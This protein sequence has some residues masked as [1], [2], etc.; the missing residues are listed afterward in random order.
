MNVARAVELAISKVI[1]DHAQ[2]GE[3][4][5]VRPWQ[6]LRYDGSWVEDQDRTF[7]VVSVA[8]QPPQQDGNESTAHI[9][10]A[11]VMATKTDDDRDHAAISALYDAVQGVMDEAYGQFMRQ[12][13]GVELNAITDVLAQE[14]G[15]GFH[16]GGLSWGNA[17]SPNEDEGANV[18]GLS[19]RVHYGRGDY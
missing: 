2:M 16:F 14:L 13:P 11:V 6:T 19:I 17:L 12:S 10:C 3:G 4:V 5:A 18:I 9:E 7:P 8:A 15:T 1:R